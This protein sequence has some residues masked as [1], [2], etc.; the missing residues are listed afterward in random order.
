[1]SL[2][3]C[4]CCF[5]EE[6]NES[7][8]G[9]CNDG[10]ITCNNCMLSGIASAM[11]EMRE[12]KCPDGNNCTQTISERT[13]DTC[14]T[15]VGIKHAYFEICAYIAIRDVEGLHKCAFC[16]YAVILDPCAKSFSCVT[17][18]KVYCVSCK[19]DAHVG[20]CL[21]DMDRETEKQ[22]MSS[23]IKCC[24]NYPPFV[25]IDA[26][27]HVRCLCGTN[28]CWYCKGTCDVVRADVHL[29]L[30]KCPLYDDPHGFEF[31]ITE[32]QAVENEKI[33]RARIAAQRSINIDIN[34]EDAQKNQIIVEKAILLSDK[35][36]LTEL[37]L[38]LPLELDNCLDTCLD[39][40]RYNLTEQI[41]FA[42]SVVDKQKF[43]ERLVKENKEQ[44]KILCNHAHVLAIA[45]SAEIDIQLKKIFKERFDIIRA[46]KDL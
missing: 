26:C 7:L 8:L 31:E 45:R 11:S 34:I 27:N 3:R 20:V 24:S 42:T 36:N 12:L 37:L 4:C 39:T 6:L 1:M 25:K 18:K 44:K 10:H 30:K 13:I 43:I 15:D 5:D 33:E 22:I 14:V 23:S 19:Q 41:Q 38:M 2:I 28:W 29:C 40:S 35:L 21:T 9:R 46:I 16:A 32:E 17:C